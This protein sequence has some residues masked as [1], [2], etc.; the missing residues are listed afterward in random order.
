MKQKDDEK[1]IIVE[2]LLDSKVTGLIMSLE[3]TRKNKFKKKLNRL[4]Y[5]RNMNGIFNHREL[6]KHTVE[7]EL[8]YKGYK[9]RIEIDVIEEQ[10]WSVIL[11][12]SWLVYHNPE[13]D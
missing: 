10:K 13:I 8:L 3:F 11:E 4:I 5:I 12:I 2:A 6:I 1:G 7:V 9:E